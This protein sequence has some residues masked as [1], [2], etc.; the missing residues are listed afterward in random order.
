VAPF[1]GIVFGGMARSITR[2][3][4]SLAPEKQTLEK[5]ALDREPAPGG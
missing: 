5:Q 4:E 1:H 2:A 3:A